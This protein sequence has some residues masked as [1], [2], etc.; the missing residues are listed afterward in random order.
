MKAVEACFSSSFMELHESFIIRLHSSLLRVFE[1]LS[2]FLVSGLRRQK[3][4]VRLQLYGLYFVETIFK[5]D[6]LLQLQVLA[7][8]LLVVVLHLKEKTKSN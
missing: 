8:H 3:L 5:K 6:M 1:W 2:R 7:N 4:A